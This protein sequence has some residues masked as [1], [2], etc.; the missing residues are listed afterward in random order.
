MPSTDF[1]GSGPTGPG[2]TTTTGTSGPGY[3]TSWS[4]PHFGYK[5]LTDKKNKP[6]G[7]YSYQNP[8]GL[9][10]RLG[11]Q[12]VAG[13]WA[14]LGRNDTLY[15]APGYIPPDQSSLTADQAAYLFEHA[16]PDQLAAIQQRM[17]LAGLYGTDLPQFGVLQAIDRTAFKQALIGVAAQGDNVDLGGYLDT[18]AQGGSVKT[19]KPLTLK[20]SKP[21]DIATIIKATAQELYGR[22]IDAG[23]LAGLVAA[24]QDRE[25]QVQ[26]DAYNLSNSAA[27]GEMTA[28]LFDVGSKGDIQM[29]ADQ[30]IR[31]AH[32]AQVAAEA[33]GNKMDLLLNTFTKST[34]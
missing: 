3:V 30:R 32:P 31:D 27:G 10:E 33:F 17:Y 2:G 6:T 19:Q 9:G 5:P 11:T 22:D 18:I 1:G 26:T 21:E 29:F 7:K 12:H 8:Y 15:G 14:I 13:V 28:P 34:V 4:D 20:V 16:T 23:E 24:Y 25:R